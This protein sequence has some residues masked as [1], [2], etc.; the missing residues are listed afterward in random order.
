MINREEPE[1]DNHGIVAKFLGQIV[2]EL[3]QN[4]V[5]H[6]GRIVKSLLRCLVWEYHR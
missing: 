3:R 5:K 1:A 2:P 4:W 6:N